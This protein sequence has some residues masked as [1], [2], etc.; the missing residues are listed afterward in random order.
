MLAMLS[1][2]PYQVEHIYNPVSTQIVLNYLDRLGLKTIF[3]D[4]LLLVSDHQAHTSTENADNKPTLGT[5]DK[6]TYTVTTS[7]NVA[8][9]E[10]GEHGTNNFSPLSE[11]TWQN[12]RPVFFD[13]E[14]KTVLR[15]FST[16][17]IINLECVAN[18][19]LR[20][21]AYDF[22]SCV[23]NNL[24]S[25]QE[26]QVNEVFFDYQI[27]THILSLLYVVFKMSGNTPELFRSYLQLRSA[28]RI[29]VAVNKHQPERTAAIIREH[30]TSVITKVACAQSQPEANKMEQASTSY[31]VNFSIKVQ[32]RRPDMLM[33]HYP[34]VVRNRLL[35]K[36]Y[37]L[38]KPEQIKPSP[39]APSPFIAEQHY[40]QLLDS[41]WNIP[42][43]AVRMPW[44]DIWDLPANSF[45]PY[46]HYSPILS[47]LVL[48]DDEVDQQASTT[49]DL[50]QLGEVKLVQ[51]V[52]DG[53]QEEDPF[54]FGSKYHLCLYH[55]NDLVD[56]KYLT[57]EYPN[58]TIKNRKITGTYRVILF[59]RTIDFTATFLPL[60]TIIADIEVY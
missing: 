16:P 34:P 32:L 43:S 57:W 37:I 36:E 2:V 3:G 7:M 30:L 29:G 27:P 50:T 14:T 60:R 25:T 26:Y 20:S 51:S 40:R 11:G 58:L 45:M 49:I 21:V 53:L 33:L 46:L 5:E 55:N 18:F 1:S 31:R 22:L 13:D 10:F 39:N 23:L 28:N 44:Y 15:I 38:I 35:P 47:M 24:R 42:I 59:V 6:L 54:N 52:L 9:L 12:I 8:D 4:N 19:K 48:L 56:Y 17:M 41:Q